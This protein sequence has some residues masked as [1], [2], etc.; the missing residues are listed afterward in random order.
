M[1]VSLKDILTNTESVSLFSQANL[2]NSM[3]RGRADIFSR[4]II[5]G[6]GV[7]L[8]LI[9]SSR[10]SSGT[11]AYFIFEVFQNLLA[12]WAPVPRFLQLNIPS[13]FSAP[14]RRH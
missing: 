7:G 5:R 13:P 12:E 1:F 4:H 8:L 11:A 10:Y 14:G 6:M 3:K 9:S 2:V